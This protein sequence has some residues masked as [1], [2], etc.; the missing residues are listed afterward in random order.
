MN[1]RPSTPPSRTARAALLACVL[2]LAP[3]IAVAQA[4]TG[5]LADPT[6]RDSNYRGPDRRP[7]DAQPQMPEQLATVSESALRWFT[8]DGNDRTRQAVDIDSVAVDAD[9]VV[10][11]ALVIA[12]S[13]GV[14]NVSYEALHC[15]RGEYRMLAL[16]R[17]DGSWHATPD[18]RWQQVRG[19]DRYSMVHSELGRV[20][21]TGRAA[22]TSKREIER[23][24]AQGARSAQFNYN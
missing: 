13:S 24:L 15:Q 2:A 6:Y 9:V 5:P 17:P 22:E 8:L 3:C 21:C 10:R 16:A 14:R 11:Y 12:T 23:R 20:L 19:G 18:T 7:Q 1:A 4:P